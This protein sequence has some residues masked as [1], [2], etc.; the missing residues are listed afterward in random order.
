MMQCD[1][2]GRSV[3]SPTSLARSFLHS[4]VSFL[5]TFPITPCRYDARSGASYFCDHLIAVHERLSFGERAL[6]WK[7][8]HTPRKRHIHH[9]P[10]PQPL[11][12]T[13]QIQLC[14]TLDR[15]SPF[16][17][18]LIVERG[19]ENIHGTIN[20]LTPFHSRYLLLLF[21]TGVQFLTHCVVATEHSARCGS[22]CLA[23]GLRPY[24]KLC[25]ATTNVPI[26]LWRVT[27]PFA[28]FTFH[29]SSYVDMVNPST[30]FLFS[31]S[32]NDGMVMMR[33]KFLFLHKFNC[34]TLVY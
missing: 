20:H 29:A 3:G 10:P 26:W 19:T 24:W 2:G 23:I 32:T 14:P 6:F 8:G 21:E 5:Q 13:Y 27:L 34:H 28:H 15:F 4:P 30:S 25:A 31:P 16:F 7:S 17:S 9:C 33:A 18:K 1:C 11:S 12:S 22:Q